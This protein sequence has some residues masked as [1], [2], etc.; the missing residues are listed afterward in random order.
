MATTSAGVAAALGYKDHQ[1]APPEAMLGAAGRIAA[2]VEVPVTVDAEAGYGLSPEALVDALL[3]AGAAGCNLEDTDHDAGTLAEPDRHAAWLGAVAAAAA[4]R[5]YP[6][7]VNARVD[8]FLDHREAATQ[9]ERLDDAIP[10][11]RA[12]LAAGAT[13]VYPIFLVDPHAIEAFVRAA[14]GPVNILALPNAPGLPELAR[15]GVARVSYGPLLYA[16][17]MERLRESLGE[18]SAAVDALD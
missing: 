15:L 5:D 2:S 9:Q 13:C 12:Y 8:V 10:R 4:D 6:L 17:A 14:E 7:V 1:Q 3:E 11:A 16:A 18:I